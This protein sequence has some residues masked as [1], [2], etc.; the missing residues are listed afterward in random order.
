M[1]KSKLNS[2]MV[3]ALYQS[4]ILSVVLGYHIQ[5]C[6]GKLGK[7]SGNVDNEPI[8]PVGHFP[9]E[10]QHYQHRAYLSRSHSNSWHVSP[11]KRK[12]D[13]SNTLFVK[14]LTQRFSLTPIACPSY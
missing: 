8:C 9:P 2:F 11:D 14:K 6:C 4:D 1:Y 13:F 7:W 12:R 5:G 3:L 10:S